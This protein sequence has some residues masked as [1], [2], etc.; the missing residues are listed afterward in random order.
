MGINLDEIEANIERGRAVLKA[1]SSTMT[2]LDRSAEVVTDVIS[3]KRDISSAVELWRVDGRPHSLSVDSLDRRREELRTWSPLAERTGSSGAHGADWSKAVQA[4]AN[5]NPMGLAVTTA[6]TMFDDYLER[7]THSQGYE[8]LSRSL[9]RGFTSIDNTMGAGLNLLDWTVGTGLTRLDSTVGTGLTRLD[10]TVG[11]GLTR[12]D[13][14]LSRGM[15][16]L[17][18]AFGSGLQ[19]LNRTI[20]TGFQRM[21]AEFSWGLSE[22]LW[23]A[24]QQNETVAEI[25]DVLTRPLDTQ[26]KELRARAIRSYDNGWMDEALADF[27][28][29]MEKSRVDY[30]VAHYLGNIYLRTED[31]DVAANWF[32][33]SARWSRPEEPRHSAVALMHQA[34]AYSLRGTGDDVDN[35]RKA[36]GCLDDALDLDPTNIEALFQRSQFLA[37][38]GDPDRA[39]ASLEDVLDHDGRYLVRVLMERDFQD[40]GKQV[41]ELVYWLTKSYSKTIERQLR[42][43]APFLSQV[44]EGIKVADTDTVIN[45][46]EGNE[47][48]ETFVQAVTLATSLY[49]LGDFHSVQQ[50][51]I[52]LLALPHPE[53][54]TV[55]DRYLWV[56]SPQAGS[57]GSAGRRYGSYHDVTYTFYGVGG[58]LV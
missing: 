48:V 43:L 26:S 58:D 22:L 52:L 7:R 34:L 8:K 55:H 40:M 21:S 56:E 57:S 5:T 15:A 29:A 10:K 38:I 30:V 54:R 9:D 3:A 39:I 25:R 35:C 13:K 44:E 11:T 12:L 6:V 18:F 36:I 4:V 45:P 28:D 27:L 24:D 20:E 41:A 49:A 33:K 16:E 23:R 17:S 37:R 1:T 31:Y 46:Y 2:A 14:T 19:Q 42:Q 53:R 47:N 50:A 32:G 51:L